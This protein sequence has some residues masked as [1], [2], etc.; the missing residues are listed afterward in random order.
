M[1]SWAA[2]VALSAFHART[3]RGEKTRGPGYGPLRPTADETTG[4]ELL[5]LPEGFRY[6]SFGWT[7]D[8]LECG[9]P[10][11]GLHDGMAAFAGEN[12][13]VLLIRNHEI[14][15]DGGSFAKPE[16]TYD[17]KGPG[18][19]TTLEFDGKRGE[20]VRAWCAI[21]GTSR[22]CAGGSTPW[23]TWLTC[24]ETHLGP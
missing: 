5:R 3:V 1:G 2:A 16:L 14:N 20:W 4:W 10:T 22:N 23:G 8:P 21:S 17:P 9:T 19:C 13:R 15:A 11:P 18:G 12:G 6:R 7:G 24:E